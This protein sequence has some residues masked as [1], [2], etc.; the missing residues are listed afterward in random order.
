MSAGVCAQESQ[1]GFKSCRTSVNLS[2]LDRTSVIL[3]ILDNGTFTSSEGG[4][5]E[6]SRVI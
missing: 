2:V 6:E 5:G 3:S 4:T 1:E